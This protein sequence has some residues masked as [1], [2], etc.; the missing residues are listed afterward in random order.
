[1]MQFNSS[2]ATVIGEIMPETYAK[3]QA[4]NDSAEGCCS[5]HF[6]AP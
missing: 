1:M 3:S 4:L 5:V 6:L 2:S